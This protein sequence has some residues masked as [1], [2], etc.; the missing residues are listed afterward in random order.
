MIGKGNFKS[1]EGTM[2]IAGE[3]LPG[4]RLMR[5]GEFGQPLAGCER[6]QAVIAASGPQKNYM[7]NE[8]KYMIVRIFAS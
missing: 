4:C 7:Q 1:V 3:H 2:V 8:A 6:G 5:V